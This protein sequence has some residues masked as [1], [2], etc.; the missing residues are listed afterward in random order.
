MLCL[1]GF[2]REAKPREKDSDAKKLEIMFIHYPFSDMA[3]VHT[4][5]G[6]DYMTNFIP[7]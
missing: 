3:F 2:A 4:Y 5:L 1:C 7:G 6:A